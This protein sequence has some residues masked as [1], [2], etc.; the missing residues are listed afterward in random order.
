M[1]L[2]ANVQHEK[3]N[4]FTEQYNNDLDFDGLS[5]AASGMTALSGPRSGR[6]HEWGAGMVFDWQ[7]T[8]RLN[9]QAGI[10][11]NKF[12]SYDDILAQKRKERKESFYSITKGNEGYIIGTYLP[13]YKLIDNPQEVADYFA[14]DNAP[15]GSDEQEKLGQKF[16]KNT[17]IF[18]APATI[19]YAIQKATLLMTR[20]NPKHST[21]W[22]RHIPPSAT[23]D[24]RVRF[25]QTG[26]LTKKSPIPKDKT[27]IFTNT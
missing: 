27:E 10:R 21:A 14:Y 5:N 4:E 25:S 17:A 1:T 8:D 3:L 20:E 26:C 16:E 22:N 11:Y 6:R 13:Y 2:S 23:A 19:Y 9:I 7:P 15:T 24:L 18:S 12:W